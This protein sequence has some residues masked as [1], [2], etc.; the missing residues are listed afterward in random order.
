MHVGVSQI[1][2]QMEKFERE[3]VF[4]SRLVGKTRQY[5]WNPRYLFKDELLALLKRALD[6]LPQGE[7]K[8]YYRERKRPRRAG[9]PFSG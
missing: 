6:H 4:V 9:K 2:R 1:Q 8:R 5:V 7:I 3:G